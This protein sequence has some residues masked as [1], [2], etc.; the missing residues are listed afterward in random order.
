[1][2][3]H[4]FFGLALVSILALAIVLPAQGGLIG[5]WPLDGDATAIVGT[6][7]TLVGGPTAA[8]D[9]NGIAGGAL[10]FNGA[11]QQYVSIAGGGGL[12]GASTATI[13][14]WVQWNGLQGT[15]H[16]GRNGAVLGRQKNGAFSDNILAISPG[17]DPGSSNIHWHGR[18][19][20]AINSGIAPGSGTWRH[21][22]VTV[23]PGGEFLYI[24]G[25]AV[26]SRTGFSSFRSD[27]AIPLTIG[28][29]IGDGNSYS[30]SAID[31]VAIWNRT[32]SPAQI[33]DLASQ[34]AGP[35]TT[36][37][38][39]AAVAATASSHF[40]SRVA[41]NTIDGL[42]HATTVPDGNPGQ[43]QGMWLSA[44]GDRTG[45]IQFDYGDV[46]HLGSLN[47]FNYNE[48]AQFTARGVQ[49]V[50]VQI[51]PDGTN[52]ISLGNQSFA[53]APGDHTN[54]GQSVSLLG[55][56]ARY[57]KL[58]I[59]SN[60]GD[61]GYTGINEVEVFEGP[62]LTIPPQIAP[63]SARAS[64]EL[65]AGHNRRAGNAVDGVG[66]TTTQ[67]NGW[68]SDSAGMWLSN[69]GD[70]A[71]HI[72]FDLGGLHQLDGL[73]IY[74]YNEGGGLT[75][76]GVQQAEILVS[77][78][79]VNFT[80]LG[81]LGLNRGT[82]TAS[83]PG[84]LRPTGGVTARYVMLDI[85]SN[86]G[87]ASYTGLNEV[88]FFGTAL[89]RMPLAGVSVNASSSLYSGGST[90]F[91]RRAV[92]L[93]DGSGLFADGHSSVAEGISWLSAGLGFGG[94]PGDD[95]NPELVFD[96]GDAANVQWV[97]IWNYNEGGQTHRGVRELEILGSADG[98]NYHSLGT[99]T[100]A[101]AP[102]VDGV[103]FSEWL[104]VGAPG[105]QFLKFDILS[106]WNNVAYPAA[107]GN[108]G[109]DFAF[110]GLSEVRFYVPEPNTFLLLVP[111]VLLAM[112]PR[113]R[114]R[115]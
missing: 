37:T 102:G 5:Y 65:T 74:N 33:A 66:Q 94:A 12:D 31:D 44:N 2:R 29:W 80:S 1:M 7:G 69:P 58:D 60:H 115:P 86:Y 87:D 43:V 103:D 97:R 34:M 30:T 41:G 54:P 45:W 92:H 71:G 18:L 75:S 68:P 101:Q 79:N 46:R 9:R 63:V 52:W 32:L 3:V 107:V 59:L 39:V 6:T 85:L 76:R 72:A 28:A 15:G 114:R 21:V 64:S 42:G 110:V 90:G 106:N 20:D 57:V 53:R 40:G 11:Q 100:L 17:T 56:P 91:D 36:L 70:N 61:T 93:V 83:N 16:G 67:P 78:D 73:L 8:A 98:A 51:S 95:A 112:L 109:N 81:M 50:D 14:M 38:P 113:R 77:D 84:Q 19:G 89:E 96:L 48:V 23:G 49:Q 82:G 25:A 105:V 108:A 88:E 24:D 104:T 27:P 99:Y 55:L 13:S 26:A 62:A 4:R 35:L 10:A 47:L 22:A 111:G